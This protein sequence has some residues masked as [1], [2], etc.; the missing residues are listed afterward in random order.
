ML[1]SLL[2]LTSCLFVSSLLP[3]ASS[4][5]RSGRINASSLHAA[6]R[7]VRVPTRTYVACRGTLVDVVRLSSAPLDGLLA[8]CRHCLDYVIYIYIYV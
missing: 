1:S 8:A 2:P 5:G 3:L 7:F 4:L 6:F